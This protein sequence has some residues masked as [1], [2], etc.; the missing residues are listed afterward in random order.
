MARLEGRRL[1]SELSMTGGSSETDKA[2]ILSEVCERLS[3]GRHT[4]ASRILSDKYPF[5]PVAP[6][7]RKYSPAECF[8]IFR[9]DGF[10]DQYSGRR[11][12]Y[13]GA[14]RLISVL[15]PDS[16]PFHKNWKGDACH[17]AYYELFPTIDHLVPVSRGG[18]NNGD[19]LVTTSMLRNAAKANFTLEELGW[20]R[21]G[22]DTSSRWDG[23]V[24][25]FIDFMN[26]EPA[27]VGSDSYLRRWYR[28]A[29]GN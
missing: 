14:L 7:S 21:V 6:V 15:L 28:G 27:Y 12:I 8:A 9:R 5:T 24:G 2:W 13:P 16:F 18:A 1:V 11:L 29:L 19:N 26:R 17:F 20:K 25:W 23:L 4:D 10:I 3:E 22:P